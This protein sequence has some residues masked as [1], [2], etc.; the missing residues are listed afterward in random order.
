MLS[1]QHEMIQNCIDEFEQKTQ[2][3][4]KLV[5]EPKAKGYWD[6]VLGICCATILAFFG[7]LHFLNQEYSFVVI[8]LE[9]I[10][11]VGMLIVILMPFM[12]VRFFVSSSLKKKNVKERALFH[13]SNHKVYNTK[14]RSGLLL[15]YSRLERTGVFIFDEGIKQK[16]STQELDSFQEQFV[17]ALNSKNFAES[18][19]EF[20][21]VFGVFCHQKWPDETFENEIANEV[22][23]H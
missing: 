22:I 6:Y 11:L 5:I 9:A 1:D 21:R 4:L 15:Y 13:F 3:E 18:L 7:V 17:A 23:G 14:L 20:I 2:V 10:L 8:Y 19:G 12:G 16:I